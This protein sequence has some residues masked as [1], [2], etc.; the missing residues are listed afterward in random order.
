MAT[1]M[2][3]AMLVCSLWGSKTMHRWLT[4]GF[5]CGDGARG[6]QYRGFVT[7]RMLYLIFVCLAGWMSLFALGSRQRCRITGARPGGRCAAAAEPETETGLGRPGSDRRPGRD[8]T[9]PADGYLRGAGHYLHGERPA[10]SPTNRI[11]A[12]LR[13]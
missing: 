4:C 6:W 13:L 10:T 1:A 7:T 3:A 9:R 12:V 8:D 11:F 5:A 2:K